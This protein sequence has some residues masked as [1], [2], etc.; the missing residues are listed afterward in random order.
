MKCFCILQLP[1]NSVTFIFRIIFTKNWLKSS[2]ISLSLLIIFNVIWWR[3]LHKCVKSGYHLWYFS[4][5]N[6]CSNFAFIFNNTIS[7]LE[8]AV[9]DREYLNFKYLLRNRDLVMIALFISDVMNIF[10]WFWGACSLI[11]L[12]LYNHNPKMPS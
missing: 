6:D 2:Q 8:N 11:K 4:D 9:F 7:S 5:Q 12:C 1:V 10:D 3:R